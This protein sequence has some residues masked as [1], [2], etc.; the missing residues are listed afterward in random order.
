MMFHESPKKPSAKEF[1]C[2]RTLLYIFF[3]FVIANFS[4][5]TSP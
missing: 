3:G 1:D 2:Q 4:V 5:L